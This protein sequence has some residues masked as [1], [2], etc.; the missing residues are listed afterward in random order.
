MCFPLLDDEEPMSQSRRQ[1]LRKALRDALDVEEMLSL[2]T[3]EWYLYF[4]LDESE[5]QLMLRSTTK[6]ARHFPKRKPCDAYINNFE[7]HIHGEFLNANMDIQ[8][9]GD[10]HRTLLY[11]LYYN[12]KGETTRAQEAKL[13]NR[14]PY[15]SRYTEQ[16]L[17]YKVSIFI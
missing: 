12:F 8:V 9:V 5:V 4:Y 15:Q 14:M 16:R 13:D 2:E 1:K 17:T 3:V 11:M 10:P 7:P 6:Y